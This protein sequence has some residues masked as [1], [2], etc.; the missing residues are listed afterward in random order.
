MI[1][2]P[3]LKRIDVLNTDRGRELAMLSDGKLI[4]EL[5]AAGK[6]QGAA[7]L[8]KELWSNYNGAEI[9]A[10]RTWMIKA[11]LMSAPGDCPWPAL[12]RVG[13]T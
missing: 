7:T 3:G 1:S 4:D 13:Q 12:K 5:F 9:S 6:F 8:M 11:I 10:L 2:L